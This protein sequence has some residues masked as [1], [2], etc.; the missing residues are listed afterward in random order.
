[1][2]VV[3]GHSILDCCHG[4]KVN[5][6]SQSASSRCPRAKPLACRRF[7]NLGLCNTANLPLPPPHHHSNTQHNTAPHHTTPHLHPHTQPINH[8][9]PSTWRICPSPAYRPRRQARAGTRY[10]APR[11]DCCSPAPAGC[12]GCTDT[13]GSGSYS[14]RPWPVRPDGLYRCVSAPAHMRLPKRHSRHPYKSPA[15][16]SQ[17]CRSRFIYWPRCR[18]L[19]RRRLI[20]PRGRRAPKHRVRP[21]P[22]GHRPDVADFP[23]VLIWRVRNRCQQLPQ[24]HGREPGQPD[25]LRMVPGPAQGVPA[26]RWTVLER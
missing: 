17:R 20:C 18:W 1:M 16:T 12:T 24:V 7:S 22:P 11:I 21:G 19:V 8:H 23:D 15:N 2:S 13:A 25:H 26:G 5:G 6:G 4:G 3:Y 14:P 9:G 10:P